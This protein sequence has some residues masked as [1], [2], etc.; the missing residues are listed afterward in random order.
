MLPRL[1]HWLLRFELNRGT[2]L[3]KGLT[4][5]AVQKAL[6]VGGAGDLGAG[7]RAGGRNTCEGCR[8]PQLCGLCWTCAGAVVVHPGCEQDG[9]CFSR[10][11]RT[12]GRTLSTCW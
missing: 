4:L 5:G 10:S 2:M 12:S 1:S 9:F 11:F 6:Q 8:V 3:D 7:G